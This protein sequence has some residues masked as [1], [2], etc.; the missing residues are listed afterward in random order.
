MPPGA[1]HV[2]PPELWGIAVWRGTRCFFCQHLHL[3]SPLWTLCVPA[4]KREK[5]NTKRGGDD[6]EGRRQWEREGIG[7]KTLGSFVAIL[8]CDSKTCAFY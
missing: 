6:E 3:A 5:R 4:S 8:H 7:Q 1:G 2:I